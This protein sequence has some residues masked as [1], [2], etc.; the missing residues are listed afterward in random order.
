MRIRKAIKQ[1]IETCANIQKETLKIP[2]K[3]LIND[4]DNQFNDPCF[5][6]YIIEKSRQIIGFITAKT[7]KWNKSVYLKIYS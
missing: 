4:L 5:F 7:I 3:T 6:F 1:D 2:K